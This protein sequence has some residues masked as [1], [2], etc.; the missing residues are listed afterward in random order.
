[1]TS[2][3]ASRRL[4][5]HDQILLALRADDHDAARVLLRR[6]LL[7]LPL[8]DCRAR[9]DVLVTLAYVAIEG[10]RAQEGRAI[11]NLALALV[12]GHALAERELERATRGVGIR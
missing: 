1:M 3:A 10:G 11:A 7:L 12:P 6:M 2:S 9:A 5:L 4:T 8:E